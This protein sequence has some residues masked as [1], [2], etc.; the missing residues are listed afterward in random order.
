M[1]SYADFILNHITIHIEPWFRD[2]FEFLAYAKKNFKQSI[3]KQKYNFQRKM[4][5]FVDFHAKKDMHFQIQNQLR[6]HA[7]LATANGTG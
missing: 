1:S 4:D 5:R 2:R 3:I 6:A 7:T